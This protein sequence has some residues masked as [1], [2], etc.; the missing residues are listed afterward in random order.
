MA[1]NL[2]LNKADVQAV[3]DMS[4]KCRMIH[5]QIKHW[6]EDR[7]L[8]GIELDDKQDDWMGMNVISEKLV[9]RGWMKKVEDRNSWRKICRKS[10]FYTNYI[11][12]ESVI[13]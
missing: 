12:I 3:F 10:R 9:S 4:R 1:Y 7:K 11:A 6:R 5:M 2:P 8:E 13:V